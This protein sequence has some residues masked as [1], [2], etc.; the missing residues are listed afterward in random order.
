MNEVSILE[1]RKR[2]TEA[3]TAKEALQMAIVD[4]SHFEKGP[5]T[6]EQFAFI[7]KKDIEVIKKNITFLLENNVFVQSAIPG[8]NGKGKKARR[9]GLQ[10][11]IPDSLTKQQQVDARLA[12][13]IELLSGLIAVQLVTKL[14]RKFDVRPTQE[15]M[16]EAVKD[17]LE[18]VKDNIKGRANIIEFISKALSEETEDQENG[19]DTKLLD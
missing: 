4:A 16:F 14:R 5:L 6:D 2:A 18:Y 13:H 12:E 15:Y 3:K 10:Q 11:Y 9:V 7:F 8:T 17:S 19:A 1:K